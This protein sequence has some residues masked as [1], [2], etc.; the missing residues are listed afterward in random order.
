M[1]FWGTLGK[2]GGAI[3]GVAGAPFTGGGSLIPLIGT[4]MN[5]LSGLGQGQTQNRMAS[6][7]NNADQDRIRLQ[8]EQLGLNTAQF[9]RQAPGARM[10]NAVHGDTIANVQ[11]YQL[12]G[13]GRTLSATGGLRPSLLSGGTRQLGAD[14]SRQ[15]LLSQMGQGGKSDPYTYTPQMTAPTPVPQAGTLETIGNVAG[16]A[17]NALSIYQQLLKQQQDQAARDT[18]P[19][20]PGY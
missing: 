20:G 8:L 7:K 13:S 16:T 18:V 19:Q 11:D 6:M 12:G 14:V 15:A 1:S 4:G 5:V 3:A 9:N 17:G 10:G 2:I